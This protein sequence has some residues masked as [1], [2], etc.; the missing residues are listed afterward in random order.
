MTAELA[1]PL[2]S[3]TTM[4]NISEDRLLDIARVVY[5]ATRIYGH[6]SGEAWQPSWKEASGS[7]RAAVIAGVKAVISGT[8]SAPEALHAARVGAHLGTAPPIEALSV[9]ERQKTDLFRAVVMALVDGPCDN[10]C[11]DRACLKPSLHRCHLDTCLSEFG[12]PPTKTAG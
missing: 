9:E 6:F 10:D 11:H 1:S 2:L 3:E 8:A 5:G 12:V 7:E 4:A